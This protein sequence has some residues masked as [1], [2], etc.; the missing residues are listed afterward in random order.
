MDVE[1]GDFDVL[2]AEEVG[3]S[4]AYTRTAAGKDDDFFVPVIIIAEV[5]VQCASGDPGAEAG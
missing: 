4:L 3:D 5:V 2:L 1:N